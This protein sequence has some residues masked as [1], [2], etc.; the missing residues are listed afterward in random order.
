MINSLYHR[1]D[2]PNKEGFKFIA[3]LTDGTAF[4]NEVTKKDNGQHTCSRFTEM[5]G[6]LP[7]DLKQP[8][9]NPY[10]YL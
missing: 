3:F 2:I 4:E 8:V 10:K 6:W 1:K 5:I 9:L 7:I